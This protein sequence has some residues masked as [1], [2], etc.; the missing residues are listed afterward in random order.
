MCFRG[1]KTIPDMSCFRSSKSQQAM[2]YKWNAWITKSLR[3]TYI[4]LAN[5]YLFYFLRITNATNGMYQR[6]FRCVNFHNFCHDIPN[7]FI[8]SFRMKY[9]WVRQCVAFFNISWHT[10]IQLKSWI[11]KYKILTKCHG[12]GESAYGIAIPYVC[13]DNWIH[14]RLIN[15]GSEIKT[16]G[17]WWKSCRIDQLSSKCGGKNIIIFLLNHVFLQNFSNIFLPTIGNRV[18]VNKILKI[19]FGTGS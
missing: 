6:G 5:I 4:W 19:K 3:H 7:C 18:S 12:L 10:Y 2:S 15:A 8:C 14:A 9:L 11:N 16:L 13:N 17:S 1:S